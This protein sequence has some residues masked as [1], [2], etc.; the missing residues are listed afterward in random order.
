MV[1]PKQP[2]RTVSAWLALLVS[3]LSTLRNRGVGLQVATSAS[4][5]TSGRLGMQAH[6]ACFKVIVSVVVNAALF[7]L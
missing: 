1:L 5:S 2:V 6:L 7:S 4:E 3:C